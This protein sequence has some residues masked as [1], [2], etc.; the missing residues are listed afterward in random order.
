VKT[1]MNM[2]FWEVPMR[3]WGS[4]MRIRNFTLQRSQERG[5]KWFYFFVFTLPT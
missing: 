5:G 2:K 3:G 4:T 1:E